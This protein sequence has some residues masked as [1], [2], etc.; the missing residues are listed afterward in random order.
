LGIDTVDMPSGKLRL[1]VF[2]VETLYTDGIIN[3]K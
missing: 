3:E 1:P 2:I